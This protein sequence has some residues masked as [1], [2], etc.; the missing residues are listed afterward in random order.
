MY[1]LLDK[2]IQET[3]K[4]HFIDNEKTV[5]VVPAKFLIK[6]M[7]QVEEETNIVI[8][9]ELPLKYRGFEIYPS[10]MIPND[11]AYSMKKKQYLEHK[12]NGLL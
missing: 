3:E 10:L 8:N 7:E 4:L 2:M 6:M 11:N 12:K 1:N 9:K 5:L